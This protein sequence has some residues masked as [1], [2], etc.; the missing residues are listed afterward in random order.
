LPTPTPA[1]P[2]L[3]WLRKRAKSKLK[4]L[5]IRDPKATLAQAQLAVAREHG[6]PSWRALH[7]AVT[8]R[9]F[10]EAQTFP[11]G[12]VAGFLR[13]VGRGD[14]VQ[15]EV[16]LRAH[17]GLVNA[18][19]PHPFWGG[20]PQAL[21]VAIETNRPAM[22]KL[23][24]RHGAGV[25]G[26]N[27]EYDAWSPLLLTLRP[28]RRGMR[29]LLLRRGARIGLVEALAMG[30][31]RRV[32]KLLARGRGDLPEVV[33]NRGSLLMFARTPRA[34]DRLL[35][36]GVSIDQRDRW[37]ASPMEALSRLGPRG[38]ALVR[39]LMS[40]GAATDP[41]AF[42]RLNDRAT[43]ARLLRVDPSLVRRP[44]VFKAAVELG[45]HR[46]AA[47]LLD[48]GADPDARSGAG[49][50]ETALHSAAWNGDARMVELLLERGADPTLRD[51]QHDGTPRDW[52]KTSVEVTNNP[53]CAAVSERLARAEVD[54]RSVAC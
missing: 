48:Q 42:A 11:E 51:H 50:I 44:G 25:N 33:P 23:L 24:L 8:R 52:A 14:V 5:R 22:A 12:L 54:Y 21:H 1:R 3:P 32:L 35:E 30:D 20:R 16:Q 29:Q 45:H 6:Y 40:R 39:H 4:A 2:S 49:A 26:V 41:E 19:G 43:L 47:W 53:A 38:K 18:V 31:D 34:I 7:A 37:G 27:A 13:L 15:V 17:P 28:G 36:L 9:A 46:L 10:P